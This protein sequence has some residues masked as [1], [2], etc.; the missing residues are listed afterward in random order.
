MKKHD[1]F[2]YAAAAAVAVLTIL[3]AGCK[4]APAA[5]PEIHVNPLDLLDNDSTFY[6]SIPAATDYELV[7]HVLMSQ[8]NGLSE[9]DA[10]QIAHHVDTIYAGLI[11]NRDGT[12]IQA[13]CSCSVPK[14]AVSKMM[15]KKNG[16]TETRLAFPK[17]GQK[18]IPYTFY[19]SK[20]GMKIA[21][22]STET[23]CVGRGVE[24]MLAQY[25][26]IVTGSLPESPLD[27]DLYSWLGEKS[28]QI[29]FYANTPQSFL[30]I[31]TGAN[32]NFK[33][34]YARGFMVTDPKDTEEY[35]LTLEFDFREIKMIPAAEG[36]LSLAFGLTDSQMV[37]VSPSHLMVSGIKID[38]K[39]L[40]KLLSL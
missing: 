19:T 28:E 5:A 4:S 38:K 15:S 10:G 35:L 8:V 22:P 26:G 14:I 20:D 24:N 21:F 27:K 34:F 3:T 16:W 39:Q 9:S 33:L 30:T 6:M 31:L 37:E 12:Q 25:N 32:L 11:R 23:A 1:V 29:R 36:M 17:D 18:E 7:S 40:Y 2:K 13:A